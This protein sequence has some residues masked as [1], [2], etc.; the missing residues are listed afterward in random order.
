MFWYRDFPARWE[1]LHREK[2]KMDRISRI[3]IR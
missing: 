3:T 1:K 2:R